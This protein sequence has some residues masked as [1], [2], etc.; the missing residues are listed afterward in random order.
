MVH[1]VKLLG[2]IWA[3]S[4]FPFEDVNAALNQPLHGTQNVTKR[5]IKYSHAVSS[6]RTKTS[7]QD[8]RFKY[9]TNPK[10]VSN[11][12][13]LGA[14]HALPMEIR[15]IKELDVFNRCMLQ[16]AMRVHVNGETV[17]S[18]YYTRLLK[19]IN[20]VVILNDNLIAEVICFLVESCRVQ[21]YAVVQMFSRTANRQNFAGKHIILVERSNVTCVVPVNTVASILLLIIVGKNYC[22]SCS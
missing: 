14:L 7:T 20:N 15:N 9:L 3:W 12:A 16:M 18:T 11:C 21:L 13:Y 6:I 5:I 10:W 19:R 17:C 2:P 1:F 22:I 8:D 4:C